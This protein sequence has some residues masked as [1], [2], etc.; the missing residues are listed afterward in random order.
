MGNSKYSVGNNRK[1]CYKYLSGLS[2]L[3][4]ELDSDYN[5][6]KDCNLI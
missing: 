6:R 4:N 1:N 5:F 2:S 3:N